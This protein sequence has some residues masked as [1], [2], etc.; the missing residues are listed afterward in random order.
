M[1]RTAAR[2]ADA[3]RLQ[4]AVTIASCYPECNVL[5]PIGH[6]DQLSK[7]PVIVLMVAGT[8]VVVANLQHRMM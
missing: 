2:R 1:A 5:V 4:A 8:I 7:T 3:D 6:S